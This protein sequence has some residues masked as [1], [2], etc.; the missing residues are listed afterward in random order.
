MRNIGYKTRRSQQFRVSLLNAAPV[1]VSRKDIAAYTCV[2]IS[3]KQQ[4][5]I[6]D[7]AL[8]LFPTRPLPK[9]RLLPRSLA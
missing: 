8:G 2:Y 1:C 4:Y 7:S 9:E 5:C 6:T 3:R